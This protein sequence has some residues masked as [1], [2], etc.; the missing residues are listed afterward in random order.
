MASQKRLTMEFACRRQSFIIPIQLNSQLQLCYFPAR[1]QNEQPQQWW[2]SATKY[3]CTGGLSSNPKSSGWFIL[4][5]V[6]Q[7][8]STPRSLFWGCGAIALILLHLHTETCRNPIALLTEP[9]QSSIGHEWKM[10]GKTHRPREGQE[11]K[12]NVRGWGLNHG[13]VTLQ[14]ALHSF[15][16][17]ISAALSF[18]E[19]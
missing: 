2:H 3:N 16:T 18:S 19:P 4:N 10:G 5:S 7:I 6:W 15:N 12:T 8:S 1:P 14:H 17:K 11:R 13:S 9:A